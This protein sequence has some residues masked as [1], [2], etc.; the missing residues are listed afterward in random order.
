MLMGLKIIKT[1]N[2]YVTCE[3]DSHLQTEEE[4]KLRV[5]VSG[6]SQEL[7]SEKNRAAEMQKTVE[8]SQKN[9]T[10]LQSDFYGKE[11]EVSALRQDLKVH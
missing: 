5:Q 9:F 1:S 10:K 8:H 2:V 4:N 3:I 7:T 6:L 11:S